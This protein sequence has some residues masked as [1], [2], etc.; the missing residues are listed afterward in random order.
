MPDNTI[1]KIHFQYPKGQQLEVKDKSFTEAIKF[2]LNGNFGKVGTPIKITF[3]TTNKILYF[4]DDYFRQFIQGHLSQKEV[5]ELT[6][7]D[8][9]F[10]NKEAVVTENNTTIDAHS[11]WKKE[12][13]NYTL[14]DNDNHIVVTKKASTFIEV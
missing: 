13:D 12:A 7:C 4:D 3:P 5:I 14:V 1:E 9:L 2:V 6:Q 10:R 11:L 8:G